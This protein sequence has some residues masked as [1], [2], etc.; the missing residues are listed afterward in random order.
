MK[1]YVIIVLFTFIVDTLLFRFILVVGTL[2]DETQSYTAQ[3]DVIFGLIVFLITTV[4]QLMYL[5]KIIRK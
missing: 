4:I 2:A 3:F 5:R 1:M